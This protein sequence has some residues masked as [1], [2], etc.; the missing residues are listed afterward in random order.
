M[1][2]QQV[3]TGQRFGHRLLLKVMRLMSGMEPPDVVR[4]V[5]ATLGVEPH[6]V[7]GEPNRMGAEMLSRMSRRQAIELMSVITGKLVPNYRG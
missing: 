3:A 6:V 4:E 1:R 7:P 2:L 5:L